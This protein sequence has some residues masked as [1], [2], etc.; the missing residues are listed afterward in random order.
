VIATARLIDVV[1]VPGDE[2]YS[3]EETE[4]A[5]GPYTRRRR[6]E[7]SGWDGEMSNLDLADTLPLPSF[8]NSQQ[9]GEAYYDDYSCSQSICEL[10]STLLNTPVSPRP[11]SFQPS[12]SVSPFL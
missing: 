5:Q 2:G 7:Q 12:K 6:A 10:S 8:V 9:D 3:S 11:V 1:M 4:P